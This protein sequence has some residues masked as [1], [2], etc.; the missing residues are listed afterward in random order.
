MRLILPMAGNGQRF[1]DAGYRCPK[2]LLPLDGWPLYYRA[3]QCLPPIPTLLVTTEAIA[4]D[5]RFL[6][7]TLGGYLVVTLT[8]PTRGPVETLL[9]HPQA[10]AWCDTT[11]ALII[12][13]CDSLFDR[14]E[15]VGAV[16]RFQTERADGGVTLRR[17][18]DPQ[19]SYATVT[20][21]GWVTQTV[22]KAVVSDWSTTGP[23]YWRE[24]RSFVACATQALADGVVSVSPVYNYLRRQ[25]GNILSVPFT[26]FEH[27]GTPEAYEH[28]RDAAHWTA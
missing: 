20:T 7:P 25:G 11:E 22:E 24:G 10:R 4:Q 5:H 21:G 14:S 13:D 23:Y 16:Q 15:W 1:V 2:P 12:A 18:T 3:L 19:C 6:T 8:T 17:T 9:A 26:S 27:L 28:K